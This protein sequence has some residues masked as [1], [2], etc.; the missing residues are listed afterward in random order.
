MAP[1][2]TIGLQWSAMSE[3]NRNCCR[4]SARMLSLLP[5]NPQCVLPSA[6]RRLSS[7]NRRPLSHSHSRLCC[8]CCIIAF[9]FGAPF[10][11]LFVCLFVCRVSGTRRQA[12]SLLLVPIV[13]CSMHHA[14]SIDH[15][16][17]ASFRQLDM[18]PWRAT[19]WHSILKVLAFLYAFHLRLVAA[20]GSLSMDRWF[21]CTKGKSP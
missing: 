17:C 20:K 19:L 18:L 1:R 8:S 10:L 4:V 7:G 14:P 12:A 5:L 15:W 21:L 11:D 2:V 16:P 3:C 9:P 6:N 13:H